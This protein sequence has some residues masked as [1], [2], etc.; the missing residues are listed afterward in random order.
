MPNAFRI[1]DDNAGDVAGEAG[2]SGSDGDRSQPVRA[3]V[4]AGG[5]RKPVS[6][7]STRSSWYDPS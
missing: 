3:R 4:L 5:R 6:R 1:R 2:D 7:Y